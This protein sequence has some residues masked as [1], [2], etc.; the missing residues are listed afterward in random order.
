MHR[1]ILTSQTYRQ[2]S[3]SNPSAKKIDADNR[4]LWRFSPRRVEA[5]VIRDSM[6]A[7]AGNL[8]ATMGG[9]SFRPFTV[10]SYGSKFYALVDR[11][12]PE[13]NRRSIYRMTVHSAR[14]PLLE[15]LD[16][17]DPSSKTPKRNVS[18]TPTQALEM[19]NDVFVLRQAR[20]LAERVRKGAGTDANKQ[21]MAAVGLTL[22]RKPSQNELSKAAS[23][24]KTNTLEM[25]CWALLNSGEFAYVD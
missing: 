23:F 17:P 24:L 25:Y 20:I 21:C 18:T 12:T 4:L 1:L 22:C 7:V 11:D 2:A 19:M 14:N 16:C 8:N 6:L 13:F 15:A 3:T 5:E 10:S 9:P